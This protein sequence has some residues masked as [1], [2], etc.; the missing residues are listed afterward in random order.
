[1]GSPSTVTPS[2][3]VSAIDERHDLGQA[4]ERRD[5][6]FRLVA[7][8]DD[9]EVEGEVDPTGARRPPARREVRRRRPRPA[10]VRGRPEAAGRPRSASRPNDDLALGRPARCP[11]RARAIRRGRRGGAPRRTRCR[12]SSRS[13]S[14]LRCDPEVA[15][16]ARRTRSGLLLEVVEL[17]DPPGV[18]ELVQQA[19]MPGPMPRSSST[20][21]LRTSSR[22]RKRAS[23]ESSRRRAGT[24]WP[25]RATPPTGRA[26]PRTP[27]TLR[28]GGV[29]QRVRHALRV[30]PPSRARAVS[31]P[32]SGTPEPTSQ[33]RTSRG[34]MPDERPSVKNEKRAQKKAAGRNRGRT[35]AR[36][37][38]RRRP[39]SSGTHGRASSTRC[40]PA[41]LRPEPQ[42]EPGRPRLH[43][44]GLTDLAHRL[45]RD[46]HA[47]G[48]E[49]STTTCR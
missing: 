41:R 18:D 42:P 36:A 11:G 24:P 30:C 34:T 44:P 27:R 16:E 6:V 8:D 20:R 2:V 3:A 4:F 15:T 17:R 35:T 37:S 21:P 38:A 13:R 7:R 23:L 33:K 43:E 31:S 40:L 26:N 19:A 25:C 1:M 46:P 32:S 5:H 48:K 49:H 47:G 14:S 45:A 39:P 29:V 28:Q 12:A 10:G 9:G 22:R